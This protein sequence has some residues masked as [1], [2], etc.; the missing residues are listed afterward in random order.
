VVLTLLPHATSLAT[1]MTCIVLGKTEVRPWMRRSPAGQENV[2]DVCLQILVNDKCCLQLRVTHRV[3]NFTVQTMFQ[4]AMMYLW[5][6]CVL[7]TK[8]YV[9]AE[10]DVMPF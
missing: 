5:W 9:Q 10:K 6:V 7:P 8:P 4:Q 3:G 1:S 2:A